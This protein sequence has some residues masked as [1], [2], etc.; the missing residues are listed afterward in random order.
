MFLSEIIHIDGNLEKLKN[1]WTNM[2]HPTHLD[3]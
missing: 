1:I 3:L 2:T